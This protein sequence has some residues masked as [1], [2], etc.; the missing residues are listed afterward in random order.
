MFQKCDF[1]Y[2]IF[3]CHQYH[4]FVF[5]VFFSGSFSGPFPGPF[6]DFP[7]PVLVLVPFPGLFLSFFLS[8]FLGIPGTEF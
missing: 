8:E 6:M 2:T 5:S 4:T 1:Q 7:G 3:L